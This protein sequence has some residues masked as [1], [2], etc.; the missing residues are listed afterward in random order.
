M[1]HSSHLHFETQE[2]LTAVKWQVYIHICFWFRWT[3]QSLILWSFGIWCHVVHLVVYQHFRGIWCLQLQGKRWRQH[4]QHLIL[5]HHYLSS[6]LHI[7]KSHQTG[8]MIFINM[9]NSNLIQNLLICC[10]KVMGNKEQI[11]QHEPCVHFLQRD[12]AWLWITFK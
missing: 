10:T 5:E 6:M 12:T 1:T 8:A 2:I 7:C 4:I 11:N 9:R 3:C